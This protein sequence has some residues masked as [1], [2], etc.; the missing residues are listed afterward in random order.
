MDLSAA[1]ADESLSLRH[2]SLAFGELWMAS[3]RTEVTGSQP[4]ALTPPTAA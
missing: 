1:K 2:P 4:L 3:Q